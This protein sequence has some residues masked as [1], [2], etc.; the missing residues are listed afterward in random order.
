MANWR[1]LLL[2][3]L[4][5]WSAGG[6]ASLAAVFPGRTVTTSKGNQRGLY[7][8]IRPDTSPVLSQSTI[9]A[10]R[11]SETET[12]TFYAEASGGQIDMQYVDI[13]D[14]PLSLVSDSRDGQLHRPDD[15][16]GVAENY[17]RTTLGVDPESYDLNLFD[18]SATP[19]DVGQGWDGLATFPGNNLAMQIAPGAGWGQLVVDHELGHRVG[20]PH[21]SAWRLSDNDSFNPYVWDEKNDAYVPYSP[22]LHGLQPVAYG[23]ELDEYGDPLSVMGNISRETFSVHQ[24]RVNMGW[25]S[26]GQVPDLD[27]TGDGV[28]RV[29][30]HDELQATMSSQGNVMG[31]VDGYDPNAYYGL[32]FRRDDEVFNKSAGV[33]ETRPDTFTLEFRSQQDGVFL[34]LNDGLLDLD[35]AGGNDRNHLERS[36]HVGDRFEDVFVNPSYFVGTGEH[37]EWAGLAAPAPTPDNE[38][39]PEWFEFRLLASGSDAIGSFVEV[40]VEKIAYV[41][42]GDLNDDGFFNALDVDR[43]VEN[44]LADTS[45]LNSVA[46]HMAGDLDNN[47]RVDLS[48]AF[49][50]RSILIEQSGSAFELTSYVPEPGTAQLLGVVGVWAA[51][52]W[53]RGD[54]AA[55]LRRWNNAFGR[56]FP[57]RR[58]R[59]TPWGAMAS[60]KHRSWRSPC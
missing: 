14:V 56:V 40:A 8:A 19:R 10:I 59:Q 12:R 4:A 27:A 5:F 44:W 29:Y 35:L 24:K 50:L 1:H 7:M 49:L 30:A 38:L 34:Y 54:H 48:D 36:L 55:R 51:V 2:L 37:D 41:P 39:R 58:R 25:L 22:T 18:V 28:Y 9:D 32:T 31:V 46:Q 45:D 33:F 57:S 13:V 17:V 23:V 20:A 21:S 16:W 6:A 3:S 60:L 15:W 47:G 52:F 43:F 53:R 42:P 26:S 11:A